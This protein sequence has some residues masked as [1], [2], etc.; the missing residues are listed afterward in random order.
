MVLKIYG[1]YYLEVVKDEGN[2]L[3]YELRSKLKDAGVFRYGIRLYPNYSELP[4][5]QD[6]AYTRWI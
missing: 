2:V 6:F 3:T 4:H 1:K 5:R